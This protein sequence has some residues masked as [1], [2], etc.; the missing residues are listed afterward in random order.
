MRHDNHSFSEPVTLKMPLICTI[1]KLE[2]L[3]A[4][5][6]SENVLLRFIIRNATITTENCLNRSKLHS[7]YHLFEPCVT[8]YLANRME[9]DRHPWRCSWLRFVTSDFKQMQGSVE[10]YKKKRLKC[11]PLKSLCCY[12]ARL[13]QCHLSADKCF[14]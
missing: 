2:S 11:S 14:F 1:L 13:V 7:M 9:S 5:D 10:R 3:R 6:E 4:A 8:V 12:A